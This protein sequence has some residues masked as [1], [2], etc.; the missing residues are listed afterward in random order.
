MANKGKLIEDFP[1]EIAS[2]TRRVI[3]TT[4]SQDYAGSPS[5]KDNEQKA[6]DWKG[7]NELSLF[8]D[9]MTL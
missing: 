1:F 2:K 4:P 9:D 3:I 5:Q 8:A 6:K 7:R